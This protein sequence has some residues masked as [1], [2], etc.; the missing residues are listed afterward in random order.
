MNI[1]PILGLPCITYKI[2]QQQKNKPKIKYLLNEYLYCRF[3][4][5]RVSLIKFSYFG[6]C[7]V[8][9]FIDILYLIIKRNILVFSVSF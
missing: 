5:Y 4:V 7:P 8:F 2:Q 1:L 6:S 3:Y 9:F